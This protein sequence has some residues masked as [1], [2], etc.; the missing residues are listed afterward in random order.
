MVAAGGTAVGTALLLSGCNGDGSGS[1]TTENMKLSANEALLK[2]SQKT[3][4]ADRFKA[5]LTVTEAGSGG[6]K[7][8]ANGQFQLRPALKFSAKLDEFSQSG[9]SVPGLKGQAV[10][11]GNT[12]YA[13][14]PQLAQFVS[15]GKSWV[16]I[17]VNQASQRTGLNVQDLVN[18]VQKVDPAEQTKMFTGSKDARRVGTET[19]D[20]V[21]TTHYTGTVTVQEALNRLDAQARDKVS[22]WLPKDRANGKINFDLWTDGENLPRKLVSKATSSDGDSGSVTVLYSDYGKSFGVNPPPSDQVGELSLGSF[23]GRGH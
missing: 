10:F 15:G 11:T 20:G 5:D 13:K 14:V 4:Q 23:L 17:D 12:L 22:R 9:Q 7:V 2:S 18:Q 19:V 16:K 6:G 3:G 1:G 21:K 8:H